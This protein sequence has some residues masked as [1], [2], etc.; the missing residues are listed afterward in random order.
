MLWM[1]ELTYAAL[2]LTDL[3]LFEA[4]LTREDGRYG[5]EL[6]SKLNSPVEGKYSPALIVYPLEHDV[7]VEME[8]LEGRHL[9]CHWYSTMRINMYMYVDLRRCF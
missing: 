4:L 8:E 7:E 1:K 9:H 5:K 3:S 2:G 6:V